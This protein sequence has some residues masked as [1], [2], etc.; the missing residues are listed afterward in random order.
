MRAVTAIEI[1][2]APMI[3]KRFQNPRNI[4]FRRVF[5]LSGDVPR[6]VRLPDPASMQDNT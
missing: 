4:C 6:A 2:T 5:S 1:A 3:A